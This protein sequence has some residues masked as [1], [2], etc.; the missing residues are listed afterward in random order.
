MKIRKWLFAGFTLILVAIL[1]SLIIQGHQLEKQKVG[2]PV[3]IIQESTPTATRAFAPKDIQL[4]QSNMQF[5]EMADKSSQFNIAQHEI[6]LRN[7]GTVAYEKIQL[8]FDYVDQRGKVLANR[9]HSITQT[10]LP[11]SSLKL[12]DIVIDDVPIPTAD[13]R[14]AVVYADIGGASVSKN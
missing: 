2:Q 14:V 9:I 11:D 4:L 6:E 5:D 8:S 13:F 1:A 10:I 12:V 3:E 7:S